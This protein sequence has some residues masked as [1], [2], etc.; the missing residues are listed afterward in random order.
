MKAFAHY[1]RYNEVEKEMK[2]LQKHRLLFK[3]GAMRASDLEADSV[4]LF[5]QVDRL[6][7]HTLVLTVRKRAR[8]IN[9]HATRTRSLH[10]RPAG[11]THLACIK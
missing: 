10:A 11:E 4:L 8:G 9:Y 5:S 2:S 6:L 1:F 3:G 7:H